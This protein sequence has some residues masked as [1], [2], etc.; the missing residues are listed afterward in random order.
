MAY[1]IIRGKAVS[2]ADTYKLY[3]QQ[4]SSYTKVAESSRLHFDLLALGASDGEYVVKA[5]GTGYQESDYSNPVSYTKP[6][7]EE[8]PDTS[9]PDTTETPTEGTCVITFNIQGHGEQPSQKE[10]KTPGT[11]SDLPILTA[12]GY[13]FSGWWLDPACSEL[14]VTERTKVEVGTT[15][16]ILY[17]KWT[18]NTPAS[19]DEEDP[20][21]GGGT[22]PTPEIYTVKSWLTNCHFEG[23]EPPAEIEAQSQLMT[24]FW[25]DDNCVW[26]PQYV[27]VSMGGT[28]VTNGFGLAG[29]DTANPYYLINI[30]S[31][32]GNV[33]IYAFAVPKVE[34][35][36][37]FAGT[38]VFNNELSEDFIPWVKSLPSGP[39]G[40]LSLNSSIE[41]MGEQISLITRLVWIDTDT[42]NYHF[43]T[44]DD[45]LHAE[46]VYDF[47]N[48]KWLIEGA[49]TFTISEASAEALSDVQKM[50]I[51]GNA[52][53]Q[54]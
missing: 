13:T 48:K 10:I 4:G 39:S 38:W 26:Y 51:A 50:L 52:A 53:K 12:E 18:A 34:V 33:E 40:S 28:D 42:L 54:A 2:G 20:E 45:T 44:E 30:G 32:T 11:L 29:E 36:E 22:L 9:D 19:G 3:K 23:E 24:T 37:N 41:S 31:V 46:P 21:T 17:A 47:K 7:T 15:S 5:F 6:A 1:T 49:R 25:L 16:S 43:P 35:P 27:K 8:I 14:Q